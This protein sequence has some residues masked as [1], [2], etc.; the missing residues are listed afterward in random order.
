M[1]NIEKAVET[2]NEI[3]KEINNKL[4]SKKV[5]N[6]IKAIQLR[7][8]SLVTLLEKLNKVLDA[9]VERGNM[10][11]NKIKLN[12]VSQSQEINKNRSKNKEN[13]IKDKKKLETK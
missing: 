7:N 11:K 13:R 4:F 2:Y 3:K 9:I 8:Y 1:T 10:N 5:L 6:N 12:S